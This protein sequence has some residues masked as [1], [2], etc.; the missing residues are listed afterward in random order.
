MQTPKQRMVK[1][2]SNYIGSAKHDE[3][4][5]TDRIRKRGKLHGEDNF[6]L[7]LLYLKNS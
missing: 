4:R 2:S 1:M 5:K 6:S 3:S 7:R